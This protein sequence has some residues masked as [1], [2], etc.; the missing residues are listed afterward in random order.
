MPIRMFFVWEENNR[1]V[2]KK[3]SIFTH[4]HVVEMDNNKENNFMFDNNL[5]LLPSV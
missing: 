3:Y 2:N 1:R 5:L 4:K